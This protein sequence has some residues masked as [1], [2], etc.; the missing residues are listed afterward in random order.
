MEPQGLNGYG[1]SGFILQRYLDNLTTYAETAYDASDWELEEETAPNMPRA[2]AEQEEIEHYLG[3]LNLSQDNTQ[4]L[5]KNIKDGLFEDPDK[6]ISLVYTIPKTPGTIIEDALVSVN[7]FFKSPKSYLGEIRELEWHG[8]KKRNFPE[9]PKDLHDAANNRVEVD[10]VAIANAF[11]YESL[12]HKALDLVN[13]NGLESS[14]HRLGQRAEDQQFSKSERLLIAQQ[15][16]RIKEQAV[17][18]AAKAAAEAKKGDEDRLA[19]LEKLILAQKD[20]QLKRGAA[21]EAGLMAEKAEAES[22]AAEEAAEINADAEAAVKLLEAAKKA[23]EEAE[24]KAA[25]EVEETK[26][27]YEKALA[28]AKAAAEELEKAKKAAEEEAANLNPKAEENK[29]PIKFKDAVGRKFSFPWHLCKTWKVRH[30]TNSQ[31]LQS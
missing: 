23:R 25:K 11:E 17:E 3:H 19:K 15:E 13:P 16:A 6:E 12:T 26:A 22:E 14:P 7:S 9:A 2:A 31:C 20:E 1:S 5:L 4:E 8:S 27:A 21:K 18:E 29:P 24:T 10:H 30:R 28:E